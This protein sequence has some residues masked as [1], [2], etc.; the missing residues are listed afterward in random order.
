MRALLLSLLLLLAAP[1]GAIEPM[2]FADAAQE[3]RYRALAHEL[4]CLMC[5]NQSLADSPAGIAQDLRREVLELMQA[6]KSDAE[7]KAHLVARYG[8]FVL[9]RPQLRPDTWLLWFGP[10]LILLL[11]A[12]G[13]FFVIRRRAIG[14]R[15]APLPDPEEPA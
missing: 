3:A 10:G 5:Q 15:G 11:G 12:V 7:I 4:R 6:G 8:D 13:L 1:L 14:S 2:D 9:Y